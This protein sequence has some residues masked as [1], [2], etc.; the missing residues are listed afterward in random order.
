MVITKWEDVTKQGFSKILWRKLCL[1]WSL[2]LVI[3][4]FLGGGRGNGVGWEWVLIS[5]W[6]GIEGGGL[7]MGAYSRLGAY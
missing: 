6:V 7:G 5:V 4:Q 1:P 3:I 2:L